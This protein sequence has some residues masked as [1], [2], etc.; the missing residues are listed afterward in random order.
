MQAAINFVC[1]E[2]NTSMKE[3]YVDYLKY[4]VQTMEKMKTEMMNV[5]LV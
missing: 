2:E 5:L 3:I 4:K 1:P